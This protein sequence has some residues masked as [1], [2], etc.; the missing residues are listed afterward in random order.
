MKIVYWQLQL[1]IGPQHVSAFTAGIRNNN[2]R[3]GMWPNI[4]HKSPRSYTHAYQHQANVMSLTLAQG[5]IWP[6]LS[7]CT[8]INPILLTYLLDI[9]TGDKNYKI[10]FSMFAKAHCPYE[11]DFES[12]TPIK[13]VDNTFNICHKKSMEIRILFHNTY[14][15]TPGKIHIMHT[16]QETVYKSCFWQTYCLIPDVNLSNV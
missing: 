3:Y 14:A 12:Y 1:Q 4:S 13:T 2:I 9:G 15:P 11:Y 7:P 8:V 6:S 5:A 16:F 10:K